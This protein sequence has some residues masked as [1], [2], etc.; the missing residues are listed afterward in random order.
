MTHA[1]EK[2]SFHRSIVPSFLILLHFLFNTS[3]SFAQQ[4]KKYKQ[5]YQDRVLSIENHD[6]RAN[7]AITYFQSLS[8]DELADALADIAKLGDENFIAYD[9]FALNE[10]ALV[11]DSQFR[12][13]LI[14]HLNSEKNTPEFSLVTIDFIKDVLITQAEAD[15]FENSL[16]TIAS[17]ESLPAK[18]RGFAISKLSLFPNESNK[19]LIR[20]FLKHDDPQIAENAGRACRALLSLASEN[21]KD[22][23]ATTLIQAAEKHQT[24]L[25]E[26][27]PIIFALGKTGTPTAKIY[28]EQMLKTYAPHGD[29]ISHTITFSISQNMDTE[30]F[31]QIYSIYAENKINF[32]D[33]YAVELTLNEIARQHPEILQNIAISSTVIDKITLLQALR[34]LRETPLKINSEMAIELLNDN[35]EMVRL[36]AVKTIHFLLPYE[37]EVTIFKKMLQTDSSTSVV[38]QIYSYIGRK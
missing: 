18:L 14:E 32:E 15:K 31:K 5:D 12:N 28:L 27:K 26:I 1:K 3:N 13:D 17:Q 10:E 34:V 6:A 20:Q 11:N 25:T 30:L 23:W 36:E 35:E 22:D 2:N 9:L 24:N 29:E 7:A 33:T 8:S 37:E 19:Q 38:Q 16:Y 4:S 21:E